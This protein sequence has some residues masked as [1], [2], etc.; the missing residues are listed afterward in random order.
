M[1]SSPQREDKLCIADGASAAA[2]LDCLTKLK[3]A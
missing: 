2:A 1:I 3:E